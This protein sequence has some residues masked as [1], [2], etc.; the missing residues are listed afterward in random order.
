MPPDSQAN[1]EAQ[2]GGVSGASGG[3]QVRRVEL[4]GMGSGPL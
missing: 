2:C 4:S 3:N 1:P